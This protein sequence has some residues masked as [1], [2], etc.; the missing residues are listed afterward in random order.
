MTNYLNPSTY[1]GGTQQIVVAER[2]V[3][4]SV[5]EAPFDDEQ[6]VRINGEWVPVDTP[7][8]VP[9]TLA[10]SPPTGLAGS[11]TISSGGGTVNYS[12]TWV[13]PT[14]NVDA[15][16]LTD[17]A[18]YV[19]RWRY[20]GSGPYATFVSNDTAAA[21]PGLVM[22]LDIEWAVLARDISGNDSSWA[23]S[24][25]TGVVDTAGPEKPSIPV[26]T[27]SLGTITARWDGL[28]AG[29]GAP[30]ADFSHLEFFISATTTGPWSYVDRVTGAGST[31]ITGIPVGDTRFVTT[32]AV[33]SSGNTSVRSDEASITVLGVT[34]PDMEANSVTANAIAAGSVAAEKITTGELAA[35]VEIIAGDPDNNYASMS[36]TGFR[37]FTADPV[38]G[39]PNEVVRMGTSSGDMFAVT[40]AA[41]AVKASISETGR[42][43]FTGLSVDATEFDAESKPVGGLSIFGKEFLEWL[44]AF[45]RGVCAWENFASDVTSLSNTEYGYGEIGFT[46][47]PGRLYRISIRGMI[48]TNTTG[49]IPRVLVRMT[50]ADAPTEAASP[51]VTSPP[52]LQVRPNWQ[53][54]ANEEY[55]FSDFAMLYNETAVSRNVRVLLTIWSDTIGTA[56]MYAPGTGASNFASPEAG[57]TIVAE[58]VGPY[59][60]QGGA[61]NT[62]G[63]VVTPV[64]SYVSTWNASNSAD[65]LGSGSADSY[66]DDLKQGYSAAS[67]DS[68]A[69]IVFAG[70]A[71]SGETGKTIA[72]ALSGATLTKV[73]VYLYANHWYYNSGGTALIRAYNSTSLSG[74]TPTGTIKSVGSWP[75]PGGKWV[76]ITSIATA[77][78]RGVTLGK[79]GSTNLLYYGRFNSHTQANKPQ[80]RLSYKR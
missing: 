69:C 45:P 12:L 6:Y 64:K 46:A 62:G 35:G 7:E 80:L 58:D 47:Y 50:F 38:D 42:G 18:Y 41:G 24:T 8:I 22:A 68:H 51:L 65:Y 26:L 76:D 60:G 28:D 57:A 5:D 48:E 21:L 73:E 71:V 37:V 36:D 19:V 27:T 56:T 23:V 75:K 54:D 77:S 13:A 25:I 29:G 3:S 31:V 49:G 33:D 15:T 16:P 72:S 10:P 14:T 44:D 2:P 30:P 53:S 59:T 11:G 43:A 70:N 40:D 55:S 78:I 79:A 9:D 20:A 52:L 66:S 67:G 39:V 4:S 34:A 1:S 63:S 74:S 61:Y 32:V 17:L